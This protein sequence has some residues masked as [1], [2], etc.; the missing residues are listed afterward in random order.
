MHDAPQTLPRI[1]CHVGNQE[2]AQASTTW[3]CN[4]DGI[5]HHFMWYSCWVSVLIALGS[6]V[7]LQMST[8]Q[9]IQVLTYIHVF[10]DTRSTDQICLANYRV[11]AG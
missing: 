11:Q 4:I 8:R 7:A 10:T 9:D 1:L 2:Y 3:V 6:I 5:L